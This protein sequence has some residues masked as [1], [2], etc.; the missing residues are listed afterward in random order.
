MEQTVIRS[1]KPVFDFLISIFNSFF[2]FVVVL[3]CC[4]CCS[5]VSMGNGK[6]GKKYKSPRKKRVHFIVGSS[7]KVFHILMNFMQIDTFCCMK[8]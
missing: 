5:W 8:L 6:E 2:F 1:I 4:L 7:N 3:L